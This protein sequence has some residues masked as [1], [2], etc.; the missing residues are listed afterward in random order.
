MTLIS[1]FVRLLFLQKLQCRH[2]IE[3]FLDFS[4]YRTK[5]TLGL[6]KSTTTAARSTT[7]NIKITAYV[8]SDAQMLKK[9]QDVKMM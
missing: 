9:V 3:S 8:R 2:A 4:N 6:Q 1:L 5:F 7:I